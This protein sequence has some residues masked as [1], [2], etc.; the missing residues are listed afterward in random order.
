MAFTLKVMREGCPYG[1]HFESAAVMR[2]GC[3]YGLRFEG[4]AVVRV[5]EG[6]EFIDPIALCCDVSC[7]DGSCNRKVDCVVNRTRLWWIDHTGHIYRDRYGATYYV[8]E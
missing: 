7:F 1:L 8:A 3:P 2:E 4:T 5:L 6:W